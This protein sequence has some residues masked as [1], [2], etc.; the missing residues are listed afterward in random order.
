MRRGDQ[1]MRFDEPPLPAQHSAQRRPR[2]GA[3]QTEA[4]RISHLQ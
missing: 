4:V 1:L 2:T 3:D